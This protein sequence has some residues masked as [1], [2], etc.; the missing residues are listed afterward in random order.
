MCFFFGVCFTGEGTGV[1]NIRASHAG[2]I[3]SETYGILDTLFYDE[4]VDGKKNSKWY[5]SNTG[6]LS[7]STDSNGTLLTSSTAVQYRC[8]STTSSLNNFLS[9]KWCVEFDV[10]SYTGN[11]MV[12]LLQT[13][14]NTWDWQF[15]NRGIIDGSH[16]K[17]VFE[18]NT[19][20]AT[21]D[22]DEKA[23]VSTS[24]FTGDLAI[25]FRF[26]DAGTLKYKNFKV[27]PV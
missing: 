20:T 24:A 17:L 21:V 5:I 10:I 16:I 2:I 3:Q 15:T 4:A 9:G 6:N 8:N 11:P 13:T 19:I 7:V 12:R 25:G 22:D 26:G 14:G 27:Y 18:D 1:L 23:P